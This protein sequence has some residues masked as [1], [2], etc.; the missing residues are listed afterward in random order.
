[1]TMVA[2]RYQGDEQLVTCEICLA[3]KDPYYDPLCKECGVEQAEQA[4]ES[5]LESFYGGSQA[6]TIKEQQEQAKKF[7]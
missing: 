1:M 6:V 5:Y 3:P 7:K 4:Y 2:V